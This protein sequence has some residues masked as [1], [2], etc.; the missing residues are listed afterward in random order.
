MVFFAFYYAKVDGNEIDSTKQ[1]T[2]IGDCAWRLLASLHAS[3]LLD[4]S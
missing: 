4:R 1:Y 2:N 3:Y